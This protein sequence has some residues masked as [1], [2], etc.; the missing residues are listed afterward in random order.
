MTLKDLK[1]QINIWQRNGKFFSGL[2]DDAQNVRH[3]VSLAARGNIKPLNFFLH[4]KG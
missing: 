2:E 1:W 4:P 3:S